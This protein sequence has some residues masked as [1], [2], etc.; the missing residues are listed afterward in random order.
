MIANTTEKRTR[1]P[2]VDRD[3]D[4]G[5]FPDTGCVIHPSCLSCPLPRC[6]YDEPQEERRESQQRRD[7]EIYDQ[8]V[9]CGHD[10]RSLAERFGVSRR[11][12]HRAVARCRDKG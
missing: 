12:V 7:R 10:I 3:L 8:Y 9:K 4:D 5:Y 2:I 6:I 1:L 11:T